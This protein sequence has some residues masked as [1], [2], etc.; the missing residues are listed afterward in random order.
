MIDRK[1]KSMKE[2][3]TMIKE[4][5]K[6]LSLAE[7]QVKYYLV[8]LGTISLKENKSLREL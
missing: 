1:K 5:V 3:G 8:T 2:I 4:T 7:R 6:E